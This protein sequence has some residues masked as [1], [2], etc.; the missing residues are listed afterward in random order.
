MWV[1]YGCNR[2]TLDCDKRYFQGDC[3]KWQCL[4]RQVLLSAKD[5]SEKQR[6]WSRDLVECKINLVTGVCTRFKCLQLFDRK[7]LAITSGKE[8][9]GKDWLIGIGQRGMFHANFFLSV[10]SELEKPSSEQNVDVGYKK[11]QL[12]SNIYKMI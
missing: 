10:L 12:S 6:T 4:T 2:H 8:F 5:R 11:S 3:V 7:I 9:F 1:P